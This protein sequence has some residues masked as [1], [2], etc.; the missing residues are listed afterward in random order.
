M[1]LSATNH[2]NTSKFNRAWLGHWLSDESYAIETGI[3]AD[4]IKIKAIIRLSIVVSWSL[5]TSTGVLM[6]KYIPSETNQLMIGLTFPISAILVLLSTLNIFEFNR[7]HNKLSNLLLA[8]TASILM[9]LIMGAK[10]FWIPSIAICY[11]LLSH[12]KKTK[13]IVYE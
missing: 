12:H 7:V 5:S 1:S 3:N 13:R 11:L 4:D 8:F 10:Y 6:A 2:L 9:I